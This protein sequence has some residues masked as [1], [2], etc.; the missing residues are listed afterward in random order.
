MDR[1]IQYKKALADFKKVS[2]ITECFYHDKSY[3]RGEIK[4][5][6]SL[7]KNGRLSIIEGNVNGQ[8]LIYSFAQ[9][10]LDE[11]KEHN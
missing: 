8:N 5:S 6:H 3:C 9:T 7:Q 1:K 2:Q 11:K 10:E 4:Q